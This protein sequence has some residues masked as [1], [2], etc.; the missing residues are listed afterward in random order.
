MSRTRYNQFCALARAAEI[1]GERWTLLIIRE[2][3]LAP[4]RF[5]DLSERLNDISPALLT[6]RLNALMEAGVVRRAA[7]PAPFNAQVYELTETGRAIQP[8]IRELIRW[9]GRFLFPMRKGETFEPDWVL[10]ALEAIARRTAVPQCRIGLRVPHPSG[11]ARFFIEGSPEGTRIAKGESSGT[12][13]IEAR[14]DTLLQILGRHLSL[15]EALATGA[16]KIEGSAQTLRKLPSL[17]ELATAK[18]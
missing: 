13:A 17:F 1:V 9:G 6:D 12:A 15:E 8:A 14:F 7:L 2:L 16:A 3:L 5:G 10:L 11:M 4:M 18:R